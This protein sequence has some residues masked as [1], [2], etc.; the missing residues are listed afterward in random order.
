[1]KT[2][3]TTLSALLLGGGPPDLRSRLVQ[4]MTDNYLR[5]ERA[6]WRAQRIRRHG[7]GLL[8]VAGG[9]ILA[10][11]GNSIADHLVAWA[12]MFT[13]ATLGAAL[14]AYPLPTA[15]SVLARAERAGITRDGDHH[16]YDAQE[17]E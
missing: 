14:A 12:V 1:M 2:D 5:F 4:E 17:P 16:D 7:F 8:L 3:P 11:L 10:T 9:A 13:V 6:W 15:G